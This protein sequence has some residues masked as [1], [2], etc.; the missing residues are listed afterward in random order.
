MKWVRYI[1]TAVLAAAI[2]Y[3]AGDRWGAPGYAVG[4]VAIY[5]WIAWKLGKR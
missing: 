5:V 2:T 3:Y 1:G 4:G